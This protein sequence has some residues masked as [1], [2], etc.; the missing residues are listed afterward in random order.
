MAASPALVRERDAV[1]RAC[2]APDRLAGSRAGV[3]IFMQ[4]FLCQRD[5]SAAVRHL[6]TSNNI[7]ATE[8]AAVLQLLRILS[9]R[10]SSFE[11][12]GQWRPI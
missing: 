1:V 6:R 10:Y 2:L 9:A 4:L 11:A 5:H 8:R 3:D 7:I 12:A